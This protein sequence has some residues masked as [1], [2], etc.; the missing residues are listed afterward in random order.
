MLPILS[1]TG[2]LVADPELRYSSSGVAVAR[3]KI[4]FS[5]NKKDANGNWVDGDKLFVKAVAFK[6]LAENICESLAKGM[7][8]N[9]TGRLKT[10]EWEKDGQKH[11]DVSLTI[12][13]LGPNLSYATAKISK[14]SRDKPASTGQADP[15]AGASAGWG[16]QESSWGS[17]ADSPPPF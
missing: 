11:F 5:S 14:V 10:E 17:T 3:M 1:G 2:R 4:A 9:V 12:D 15:Y 7:E 6:Q 16:N 8:V 13:S